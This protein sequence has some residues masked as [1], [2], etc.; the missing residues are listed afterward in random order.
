MRVGIY[1]KPRHPDL[2][3]MA[4]GCRA[5]GHVAEFHDGKF[6]DPAADV[7]EFDA[8]VTLGQQHHGRQVADTYAARGVAVWTVDLPVL[9]WPHLDDHRALWFGRLNCLP[10]TAPGDRLDTF[11]IT[12]HPP[13]RP[14]TVA[15]ICGQMGGDGAHGMS[16]LEVRKW[17]ERAADRAR[18]FGLDPIWRPHPLD[19]FTIPGLN[20]STGPLEADLSRP[21]KVAVCHNSTAGLKAVAAGVPVVSAPESFYAELCT[22]F[23]GDWGRPY[24]PAPAERRNFFSRGAYTQWTPQELRSGHALSVSEKL[25]QR[26][27][28]A[29]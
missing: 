22:P 21:L 26:S 3:A 1:G 20:C 27:R 2:S 8:V 7:R 12:L 15:L 24:W 16:A 25:W 28:L 29:A 10:A 17:A 23:D 19:A 11:G 18:S 9:R 6:F 5:L 14:G 4:E 13:R